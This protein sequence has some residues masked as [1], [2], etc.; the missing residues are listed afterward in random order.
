MRIRSE[1]MPGFDIDRIVGLDTK[2]AETIQCPICLSIL[3]NPL[4]TK[5]GHNYCHQCLKIVIESGRKDCP[6]CR[7][8]FSKKRRNDS[9]DAICAVIGHN[10]YVYHFSKNLTLNEIIGKLKINCDYEFN[11]CQESVELAQLSK[12][13]TICEHRLCKTCG[14]SL[15]SAS[16]DHNC[17]DNLK[18]VINEWKAKYEKSIEVVNKLNKER[19]EMK[20]RFDIC[21]QKWDKFLETIRRDDCKD[22]KDM[23]ML[24]N[25]KNLWKAKY[26]KIEQEMNKLKDN[27]DKPFSFVSHSDNG[28]KLVKI[29]KK[30]TLVH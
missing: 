11:G 27:I 21:H 3:D 20:I 22:K 15:I 10:K 17:I 23:E 4:I 26:E 30:H 25:E 5:C 29:S 19:D 16:V 12:H 18:N 7:I 14:L 28:S 1:A 8:K 24:K 13:T 2:F 9:L 6:K